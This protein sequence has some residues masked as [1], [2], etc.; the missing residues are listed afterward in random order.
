VQVGL[1]RSLA[2]GERGGVGGGEK[3]ER[4]AE[5]RGRGRGRDTCSSHPKS[6]LYSA[7]DWVRRG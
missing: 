5:R 2:E 3:E 4:G 6:I 1:S 7:I